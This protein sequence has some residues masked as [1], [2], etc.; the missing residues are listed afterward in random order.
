M[1]IELTCCELLRTLPDKASDLQAWG[2]PGDVVGFYG[3]WQLSVPGFSDFGEMCLWLPPVP[4]V[5]GYVITRSVVTTATTTA[6][7]HDGDGQKDEIVRAQ[8]EQVTEQV[9]K[10]WGMQSRNPFGRKG[11]GYVPMA[12]PVPAA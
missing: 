5:I 11:Q 8:T 3:M 10:Q 4:V 12:E 6:S 1:H 7:D 2:A 9:H